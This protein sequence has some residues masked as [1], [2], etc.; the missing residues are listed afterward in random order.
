[1]RTWT[2]SNAPLRE[3]IGSVNILDLV[4]HSGREARW[5]GFGSTEYK[6]GHHLQLVSLIW[7]KGGFPREGL[8]YVM[9][10]DHHECYTGDLP[11]P[12]KRLMG[13][14]VKALEKYLDGRIYESLGLPPPTAEILRY[15]KLCDLAALV[16]EAPLF[17]PPGAING[18]VGNPDKVALT[19]DQAVSP[20]Y[21]P[22]VPLE[23]QAEV[24]AL[25]EKAIPDLARVLKMR[26]VSL[27][28][29]L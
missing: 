23:F 22:D 20:Y 1:M 6:V 5:G 14:G 17:G 27:G 2:G 28:D 4:M 8:A 15:V 10:H 9:V 24:A 11:S 26:G 12:V 13:E 19:P 25:A 16:I 18:D 7:L 29:P 21:H 3:D